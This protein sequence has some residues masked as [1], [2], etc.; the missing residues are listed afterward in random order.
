MQTLELTEIQGW[1]LPD[2][3][4]KYHYYAGSNTSLCG[5]Y[6][7]TPEQLQDAYDNNHKCADNCAACQRKRLQLQQNG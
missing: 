6:E 7:A 1:V 2:M 4:R 5:G 3:T